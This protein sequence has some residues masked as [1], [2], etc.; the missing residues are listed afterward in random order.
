MRLFGAVRR[1]MEA[2]GRSDDQIESGK[3]AVET[4]ECS[5]RN[6]E[7]EQTTEEANCV[8]LAQFN[9]RSVALR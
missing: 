9:D 6:R 2:R 3:S 7:I 4:Q 8:E 5:K 1:R